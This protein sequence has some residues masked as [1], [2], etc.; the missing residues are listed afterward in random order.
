MAAQ[1]DRDPVSLQNKAE[2]AIQSGNKILNTSIA[3]LKWLKG[4]NDSAE[5]HY[6]HAIDL[7]MLA[8]NVLR[9][10]QDYKKAAKAH[11]KAASVWRLMTDKKL[12]DYRPNACTSLS[13][14]SKLYIAAH[15]YETAVRCLDDAANTAKQASLF[16]RAAKLR[17]QQAD[18]LLN[19]FGDST[20]AIEFYRQAAGWYA[21]ENS[22]STSNGIKSK[23]ADVLA[24]ESVHQ[25]ADAM[26]VYEDIG[27]SYCDEGKHKF[28]CYKPFFNAL[29][30]AM[31][32]DRIPVPRFLDEFNSASGSEFCEKSNEGRSVQVLL[33]YLLE[34]DGKTFG[35]LVELGR[36]LD[37]NGKPVADLKGQRLDNLQR[38]ICRAAKSKMEGSAGVTTGD[39]DEFS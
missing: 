34:E 24:S 13:E 21:V 33:K 4:G 9:D 37:T 2:E 22:V 27:R 31:A 32:V 36:A 38:S 7:Y 8:A 23:L 30:C 39:A 19:K 15:D 1:E 16:S 6:T 17:D 3:A 20:K 35:D 14:A 28:L 12:G 29:L 10:T 18:M 5:D 11:E 25:Y 26:K